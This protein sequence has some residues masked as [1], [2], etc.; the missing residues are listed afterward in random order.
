MAENRRWLAVF[1][2]GALPCAPSRLEMVVVYVDPESQSLMQA[3]HTEDTGGKAKGKA[4]A[5]KDGVP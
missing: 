1:L 5:K 4:W 3:G 2:K